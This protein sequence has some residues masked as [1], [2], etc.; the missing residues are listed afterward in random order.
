MA[1]SPTAYLFYGV[2]FD[3]PAVADLMDDSSYAA[4]EEALQE[5]GIYI[6]HFA[7][8]LRYALHFRSIAPSLEPCQEL[9]L[10]LDF[11]C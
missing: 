8:P 6:L 4:I 1:A 9:P 3:L 2:V 7:R 11:R 10:G 5:Y